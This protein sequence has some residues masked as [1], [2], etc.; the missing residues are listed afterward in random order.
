MLKFLEAKWFDIGLVI[1]FVIIKGILLHLNK[2][3]NASLALWMGFAALLLHHAEEY[4]WPGNFSQWINKLF[5]KG[6]QE[7]NTPVQLHYSFI[8][9]VGVEWSSFLLAA[10]LVDRAWWLGIAVM[11]FCLGNFFKH[12]IYYT[13]RSGTWYNPGMISS[14][15]F[16]LPVSLYFFWSVLHDPDIAI[17]NYCIG[18]PLGIFFSRVSSVQ[19]IEWIRGTKELLTVN[20]PKQKVSVQKL[21]IGSRG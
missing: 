15:I 9:N 10:F 16:L 1:S 5:Y 11:L 19:L 8:I 4:H 17:W 20:N 12:A 14:I 3:S 6:R 13:I 2:M 7:V 18:I 21:D